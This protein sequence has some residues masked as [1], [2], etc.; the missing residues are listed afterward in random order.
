VNFGG[1]KIRPLSACCAVAVFSF[2]PFELL[3]CLVLG[4]SS[5]SLACCST[6]AFIVF[7]D[8]LI[9]SGIVFIDEISCFVQSERSFIF[10]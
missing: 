5:P 4:F 2:G 8:Q 9:K 7:A 3:V 1:R 6:G 10:V